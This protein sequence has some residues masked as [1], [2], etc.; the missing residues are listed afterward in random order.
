MRQDQR[1]DEDTRLRT[2]DLAAADRDEQAGTTAELGRQDKSTGER[3]ESRQ[4]DGRPMDRADEET[5]AVNRDQPT[6]AADEETATADHDR[7]SSAADGETAWAD[8]NR[9]SSA[10]DA[11]TETT[12]ADR[13]QPSP[14][15]DEETAWADRERPSPATDEETALADRDR[16]S[17]AMDAE[18]ET[19]MAERE[20]SSP[21]PSDGSRPHLFRPDAAE[22]F[23]VEWQQIQAGFVDDPREAVRNADHLVAEVMQALATT[24]NEHKRELEGQWQQGST[25]E[26]EELRQALR[27]YR[28]F[29]NQ[30]LDT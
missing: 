22:R 13:D 29:F 20:Q 9:S 25:V 21:L 11:E 2:E 19:I 16:L 12:M 30:L 15:A 6:P 26:T 4:D 18:T 28:A 14:A 7:P 3:A 24:F 17:P 8:R 23:R 27:R 5:V 1:P 10:V